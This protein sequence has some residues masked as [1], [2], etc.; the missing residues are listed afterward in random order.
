MTSLFT[1]PTH[2]SFHLT[3][4][5][6]RV[7]TQQERCKHDRRRSVA[8]LRLTNFLTC[9]HL[10]SLAFSSHVQLPVFSLRDSIAS[11]HHSKGVDVNL[12]QRWHTTSRQAS[13]I[14]PHRCFI[15]TVQEAIPS[16]RG[17]FFFYSLLSQ[18]CL[19]TC[20]MKTKQQMKVAENT[21]TMFTIVSRN[22]GN[23]QETRQVCKNTSKTQQEEKLKADRGDHDKRLSVGGERVWFEGSPN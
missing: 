23:N 2:T 13:Q 15:G 22:E 9:S 11:G 12:F 4:S 1:A 5:W 6:H 3:R 7:A 14:R 8:P 17:L 16:Y 21:H 20:K 10:Q 18:S 19:Q